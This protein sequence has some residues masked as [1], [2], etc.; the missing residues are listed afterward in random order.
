MIIES[1]KYLTNPA[2]RSARKLGQL[3]EAI[4][5]EA[6][7]K[8]SHAQ[9]FSHLENTKSLIKDSCNSLTNPD[10]V[11]VLGSGLLL[12][13]PLEFL[14]NHF[15]RVF[16]VD[17]VHL[18]KVTQVVEKYE[19]VEL[20]E[21]DVTGLSRQLL[22]TET[23]KIE[24]F[25]FNVS[26]PCLSSQTSLVI[27]ANLLSQ[28]PLSL[29]AFVEKKLAFDTV[30]QQQF[31]TKIIQSH[32]DALANLAN[33]VCLISDYQRYYKD[34]KLQQLEEERALLTVQL[35]EP[36]MNWIWEIAPQGE[37]GKYISMSSRVYGYRDFQY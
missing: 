6:R 4:A 25:D 35:P 15:N 11:V 29:V 30:M 9:W 36:D 14:A 21:Y 37:L 24:D 12:D 26:I 32:L 17:V 10:E 1:F 31:A 28:L 18:K 8:R 3:Q 23:K 22:E 13:I 34:N 2:S 7:F 5:M 33:K 27:S 19:N 16:L 20:L